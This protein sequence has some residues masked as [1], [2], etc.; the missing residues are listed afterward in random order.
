MDTE[1]ISIVC[2]IKAREETRDLV[3]KKLQYLGEMSRSEEGNINYSLHISDADDCMFIIYENWANQ[4]ALDHHMSATYLKDFL[5]AQDDLLE[6]PVVG[7]LCTIL[8]G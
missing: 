5:A 7:E 8:D 2:H 3:R 1:Q 4:A 6:K